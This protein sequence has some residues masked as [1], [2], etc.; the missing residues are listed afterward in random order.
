ME[1]DGVVKKKLCSVPPDWSVHKKKE[2]KGDQGVAIPQSQLLYRL[3]CVLVPASSHKSISSQCIDLNFCF[4][5][6]MFLS[7]YC[8]NFVVSSNL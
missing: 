5:P 4:I 6:S 7:I 2:L 3:T 8:F 1:L